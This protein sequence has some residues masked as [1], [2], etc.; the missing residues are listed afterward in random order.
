MVVGLITEA[1]Q[2]EEVLRENKADLIGMSREL[3]YHG[4]WP[5]HAART[6]GIENYLAIQPEPYAFRLRK[7]EAD[8]Q[9]A[10]NT[11]DEAKKALEQLLAT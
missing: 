2:A 6:L 10:I 5:I 3:M 7:R 9:L 1:E 4:D 11:P 8:K